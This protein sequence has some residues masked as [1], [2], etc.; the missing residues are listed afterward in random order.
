VEEAARLKRCLDVDQ[1]FTV[2]VNA[3][4]VLCPSAES[5]CHSTV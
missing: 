5:A 4:L 2:K 1:G 3:P